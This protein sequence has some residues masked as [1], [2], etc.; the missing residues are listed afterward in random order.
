MFTDLFTVE[1]FISALLDLLVS[2]FAM[3]AVGYDCKSEGIKNRTL[4]MIVCFFIPKLGLILY[5]F[6]FRSRAAR[7]TPKYCPFCNA[8]YPPGMP[9]CTNCG[10]A[11]LQNYKVVGGE[12]KKSI[13]KV[14]LILAIVAIVSSIVYT[15]LVPSYDYGNFFSDN[16]GNSYSNGDK[17]GNDF[18]KGY[19]DDFTAN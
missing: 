18:D 9:F 13:S 12:K 15:A 17:S 5:Y 2:V 3:L 11:T 7:V 14:F 4:W 19:F 10:N 8:T 1:F 16:F 6:I